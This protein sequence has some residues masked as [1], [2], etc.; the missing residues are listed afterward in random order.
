MSEAPSYRT[1]GGLRVERRVEAIDGAAAIE[2]LT[3]ALDERRGVLFASSYE[4]PGRYT[5]WD[6]GF[7]DPPLTVVA[8]GRE[9]RIEAAGERGRVLLAPIARALEALPSLEA[10]EASAGSLC[11]RLAAPEGRFPE[12]ERSKQPSVFS[13]LRALVELFGSPE[14]PHLGLYGAFGYDL[15]FQFE[16]LRLCLER[17]ARQRDVV[18]FLPDEIVVVDHRRELAT[19][20]R[21]EFEADG[22]STAGLARTG[23]VTPFTPAAPGAVARPS[24]HGLGEYAAA[25]R[26]AREAFRR[27]DLFEVVLSQ[28]F[29]EPA[30][31]SPA[32]IFRRLRVRNPSPYGFLMN[33][34][35]GEYLVGASPE[36][37]VRVEG[38]RVETCPIAGTIRRGRDALEDAEQIQTLLSSPKEESELT[39]CTDVDRND[40]SRICEPGSVRVIGRRQIELYS[41]LIHTVDHVEGTLRPGFDA[42]D[43]FLCHTWAVTVTGAPKAWA[44]QFVEDHERSA[45]AWYGGAVGLVGFDGSLNTGLT[46]RTIRVLDGVAEVRA[47]ATL[48]Y[49]SDPEA[50]EEETHVKASALLDAIR[51]PAGVEAEA[52]RVYQT[53][54]GA[55]LRILLVDHQDS[56]VHTL[57]NYLRQTGAEVVTWRAGFPHAELDRLRPDLVVLSPGPGS[58]SDFD[59]P[60]TLGALRERRLPAFGVCLGLQGLVEHLGGKLDV[61]GYPVHGKASTIEVRGGGLFEGLPR[62]FR[63]GRYHS[64]HARSDAL[65][66][67]LR[68]TAESEDGVVMAVEHER[69]PLAAVQFHPESILTPG[70]IG[71]RIL[72]NAVAKLVR[73]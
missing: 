15:A 50:E 45:R 32:E 66:L 63:A 10:F 16:P 28:T 33:L 60:G 30:A 12:E 11:A 22:R 41:R 68:V 17:P 53:R 38:R 44:M 46:L 5:R 4:Y 72:A 6:L 65:P 73:R 43:A 36:M 42:L 2:A 54:V 27:G 19:R 20:R 49:D 47:G 71:L 57:A 23:T 35:D 59:V 3:A 69:E 58:P 31:A 48:L 51:R 21:Y 24:D 14:D 34:G 67:E 39:M 40:K 26:T 56:F 61:L 7:A 25:V 9:L 29:A 18:L 62:R 70:E 55:G 37:F 1:R 8:R 64:L 52:P 13:V